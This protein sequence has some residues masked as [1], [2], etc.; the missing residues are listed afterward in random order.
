MNFI[1]LYTL[2]KMNTRR[3]LKLIMLSLSATLV[4]AGCN[5]SNSDKSAEANVSPTTTTVDLITQTEIPI[6]TMLSAL[7]DDGDNLSFSL[8][9]PATLGM[10]TVTDKGEFT[11]Q[12]DNEVTGSDSFTYTVTDGINPEV[13][14]LVNISI[15]ALQVYFTSY[16]REVFNQEPSDKPLAVNGRVFN[17]DVDSSA[18]YN[19]LISQ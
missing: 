14:G 8:A 13:T 12:P 9:Q 19:D 6:T 2:M 5:G 16:S 11:Y 4:L 15:E 1:K 17:Q 18:A 10:V 7:D 3:S